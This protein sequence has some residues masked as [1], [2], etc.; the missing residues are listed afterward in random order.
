M[1]DEGD[2][3]LKIDEV[4]DRQYP[5]FARGYV[6][7]GIDTIIKQKYCGF[8]GARGFIQTVLI[9]IFQGCV[10]TPRPPNPVAHIT[11]Q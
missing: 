4:L 9:L 8:H 11:T 7:S 10:K 2:L 6:L 3:V 1:G 5:W